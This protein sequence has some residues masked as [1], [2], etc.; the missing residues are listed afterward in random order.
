MR[1]FI[2]VSEPLLD[3]NELSYLTEAIQTGWISSEGPFVK[4]FEDQYAA[5][6]NRKHG[7]SVSNGTAALEI[8]V[9]AAGILPGDEVIMPTLTIISCA[10]AVVNAGGIIVPVDCDLNDFNMLTN[11]LEQLITPRTKAIMPVHIYGLPVKMDAVLDFAD[12]NNLIVIEDAAEMHGQKYR[13]RPCGSFGAVSVFSFYANKI[14]TT[15]EGGMIVTND[16]T[17]AE[18]CRTLRNLCFNNA[19]RFVHEE[20][21]YNYRFTNIQAAVGLAQLE[22]LGGFVDMKRFIGREYNKLFA[23]NSLLQIPLASNESAENLYW[24]YPLVLTEAATMDA[25]TVMTEL[26]KAGI[27][28]RPFFYPMHLQPVL[29]QLDALNTQGLSFPNAE[30]LY[31]K[32]FYIPSGLPLANNPEELRYISET[33]NRLVN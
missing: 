15:G 28:T 22:R 20:L 27:G 8:A 21:G 19:N 9:R 4:R 32:G 7:I 25:K 12:R 11:Q 31:K 5:S 16:D 13:D 23:S 3:G 24:V 26:Q 1:N 33:I 17:I 6:V 18:K 10:Q 30:Y 14:V 29:H 2:P